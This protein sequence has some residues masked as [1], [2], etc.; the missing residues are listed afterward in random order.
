MN[1]KLIV[2]SAIKTN[3]LD[4]RSDGDLDIAIYI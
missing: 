4:F 1:L 2:N 3:M